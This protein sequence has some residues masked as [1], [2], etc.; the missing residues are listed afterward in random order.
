[1]GLREQNA[2]RTRALIAEAALGLFE[3]HGYEATTMEQIAAAADVGTSTLYRYFPT[4]DSTLLDH[5]AFDARTLADHL[6]AR[7]VGETVDSALGHA[8]AGWLADLDG[9]IDTVARVRLQIDRNPAVRARVWDVW[10]RQRATL[11]QALA[12]RLGTGPDALPVQVAAHTTL[13]IAQMALDQARSTVDPEPLIVHARRVAA[14]LSAGKV[15]LPRIP[16]AR[17]SSKGAP[18][19]RTGAG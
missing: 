7:P 14:L 11:E 5:P 2:R 10:Y 17:R 15:P 8:L 18:A 1:M 3:R 12:D 16:R 13:M 9:Q 4:K 19:R 6:A